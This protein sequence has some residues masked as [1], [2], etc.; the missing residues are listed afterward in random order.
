MAKDFRGALTSKE[1]YRKLLIACG[2]L[3]IVS[4]AGNF[5]LTFASESSYDC[6]SI[7]SFVHMI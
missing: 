3:L 2:V 6:T 5:G 1:M 7:P 4:W